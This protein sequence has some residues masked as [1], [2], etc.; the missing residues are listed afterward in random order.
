MSETVLLGYFFGAICV[1]AA[2]YVALSR[3]LLRVTIAFFVE[4][5]SLS[6]VLLTLNAA[7][8]ALVVLAVALIGTVLVISFSRV[9]MGSLK[10]SFHRESAVGRSLVTRIFGMFLGL[11]LGAAIGWAFLTGPSAGQ[12]ALSSTD[13]EAVGAVLLGRMM[14]GEQVVVMQLLAVMVLVVVVGAGLLLRKPDD[15]S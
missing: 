7:Y 11:G 9:I 3:D 12:L 13:G 1:I 10:S 2:I 5:A 8:L 14:L 15:A 6:G 4:L